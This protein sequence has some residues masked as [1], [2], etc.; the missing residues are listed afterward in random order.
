M[1]R[2][3]K[4]VKKPYSSPFLVVLDAT[5][6]KAK[7]EA[8]GDPKDAVKQKM[9]SLIDDQLNKKQSGLHTSRGANGGER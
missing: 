8:K 2:D 6:A 4:P 9:L 1:P 5:T 3:P 7:L